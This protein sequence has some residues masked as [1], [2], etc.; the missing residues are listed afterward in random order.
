[1]KVAAA[2]V[3]LYAPWVCSL[4]EKRMVVRSLVDGIQHKFR[5]SVAEVEEQDV[6]RTIVIG[7]AVV[8]GSQTQAGIVLDRVIDF[9]QDTSQA[10]ITDIQ[11]EIR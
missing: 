3:T 9:I 8:S 2:R 10:D 5:I 6:H 1:M 4:K 7:L 11:R